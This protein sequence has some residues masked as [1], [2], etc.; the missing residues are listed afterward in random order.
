MSWAFVVSALSLQR[1]L[2]TDR[3]ILVANQCVR[4]PLRFARRPLYPFEVDALLQVHVPRIMPVLVPFTQI[5]VRREWIDTAC[6]QVLCHRTVAANILHALRV[7]CASDVDVN[8]LAIEF[9]VTKH[10]GQE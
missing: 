5:D 1:V 7:S 6:E 9:V 10:P 4:Q 3:I 2:Q 8:R